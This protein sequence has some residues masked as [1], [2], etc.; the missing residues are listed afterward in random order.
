MLFSKGLSVISALFSE[1]FNVKNPIWFIFNVKNPIWSIF[2]VNLPPFGRS[3]S[4][5][6][7]RPTEQEK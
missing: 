7:G 4:E 1:S 3:V 6:G 5:T 2:N